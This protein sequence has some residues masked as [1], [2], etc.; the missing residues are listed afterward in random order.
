MPGRRGNSYH[1]GLFIEKTCHVTRLVNRILKVQSAIRNSG[2]QCGPK[3]SELSIPAGSPRTQGGLWLVRF[4]VL[5]VRVLCGEVA[6][7]SL[8]HHPAQCERRE[9]PP[10]LTFR[11]W[12][13]AAHISA[14][15]RPSAVPA[16]R[17]IA[18]GSFS[19]PPTRGDAQ[20]R[21]APWSSPGFN[22]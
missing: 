1:S 12:P 3:A 7:V 16:G 21:E 17:L 22:T 13:L 2:L 5:A 14:P 4:R 15:R 8:H 11:Q 9:R 10:H 20:V 19:H 18:L 6:A